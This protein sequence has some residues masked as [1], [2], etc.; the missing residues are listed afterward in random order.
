MELLEVEFRSHL[1]A[2]EKLAACQVEL[3]MYAEALTTVDDLWAVHMKS[4]GNPR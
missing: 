1:A 4:T 2:L 3:E